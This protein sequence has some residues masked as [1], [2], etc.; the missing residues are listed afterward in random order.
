MGLRYLLDTNAVSYLVRREGRVAERL[1]ERQRF[2]VTMSS[3]TVAELRFGG[4]LKRSTKL[5][6]AIDTLVA[7]LGAAPFDTVAADEFARIACRL[8]ARGTPIETL[9]AMLAGHAVSLGCILVTRNVS[10]F[11]RVTGLTTEDWY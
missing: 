5:H 8:R 9:D 2:E 7:E 11:S 1:L 6:R 10:H 3:I 4:E